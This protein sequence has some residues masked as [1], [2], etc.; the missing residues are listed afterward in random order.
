[1]LGF[2][3]QAVLYIAAYVE[4]ALFC[5]M[6]RGG[7]SAVGATA[8]RYGCDQGGYGLVV[9]VEPGGEVV[10]AGRVV[11][12]AG[13]YGSPAILL[14]S[15]IGPAGQLAP[16]GIAVAAD[17]P[18]MGGNLINHPLVA[19]DLPTRPGATC[20]GFQTMATVC[21]RLAVDAVP[22]LHLFAAGLFHVS[23]DVSPAGAVFGLVTGLVLPRSR[24]WLRLRSADPADPPR[25]DIAHLRHPDD[26][27][28]MIEATR[29]ARAIS[30]TGPLAGR[31]TGARP[32]S[33]R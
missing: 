31:R 22:D 16:L 2:V 27:T 26:M 20:P 14:R 25:I 11:L 9:D 21:S 6:E 5:R 4:N 30:R 10:T 18:G 17:L 7:M 24:G 29:I 32:R 13:T 15:G 28:R 8:Y 23:H 1:L 19:V 12:A 3:Q 33:R